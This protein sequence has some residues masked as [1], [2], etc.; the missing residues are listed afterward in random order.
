MKRIL[1]LLLCSIGVLH[2]YAAT[3]YVTQTNYPAGAL[4]KPQNGNVRFIAGET[5]QICTSLS[6]AVEAAKQTNEASTIYV[7]GGT[8]DE[9]LTIDVPNLTLL[10][11]NAFCDVRS[12]DKANNVTNDCVKK[13]GTRENAE[14]IITNK[15]TIIANNVTVNGFQFMGNGCV[16]NLTAT[17]VAPLLGFT[18]LYNVVKNSTVSHDATHA[19][20][21]FGHA[22]AGTEGAPAANCRYGDF[23]IQ[24]NSFTGDADHLSHFIILSGSFGSTYINDNTFYDGGC[25]ITLNNAQGMIDVKH[26]NFTNVGDPARSCISGKM[27]EFCIYLYYIAYSNTTT[28]NIQ[29]NTFNNCQG[30][31]DLFSLIRFFAGDTAAPQMTPTNCRINLNHNVFNNKTSFTTSGHNFVFYTNYTEAADIDTRFNQFS[32]SSQQLAQVRQPWEKKAQR[33]YA[34]SYF[35]IEFASSANTTLGYWK[36]E[37][38]GEIK[39]MNLDKSQRVM[40]SFDIDEETGDIYFVQIYNERET[41]KPEITWTESNGTKHTFTALR[42]LVLSRYYWDASESTM[43]LTHSYLDHAGHGQNMAA[44]RYNGTLYLTTGGAGQDKTNNPNWAETKTEADCHSIFPWRGGCYID[45]QESSTSF[46]KVNPSE[47]YPIKQFVSSLGRGNPYPAVDNTSRLFCERNVSG[48]D[49]KFGIYHLDDVMSQAQPQPIKTI[50]IKKYY[51]SV[52]GDGTN[53]GNIGSEDHGFQT[54]DPQGFTISGDYIYH[55]EGV[56]E[57]NADAID[58]KPTCIIHVHN[59]RTDKLVYRKKIGAKAILSLVHGEPE[60]LK[61]HRDADG[62]PCLL[63]GIA[64]GESGARRANIFKYTPAISSD[65]HRSKSIPTGVSTAS[66]LLDEFN[67]MIFTVNNTESAQTQTFTIQNASEGGG[68]GSTLNGDIHLTVTGKD[69]DNFTVKGSNIG[70]FDKTSMVSVTFM[71]DPTKVFYEANLRISS[72]N[73]ADINI[74]MAASN[75]TL[76]VAPVITVDPQTPIQGKGTETEPF[77]VYAGRAFAYTAHATN[78]GQYKVYDEYIHMD[79]NE[80]EV[81]TTNHTYT[82]TVPAGTVVGT[83]GS[84]PVTARTKVVDATP[85]VSTTAQVYYEVIA[86]PMMKLIAPEVAEWGSTM[87]LGIE[88]DATVAD[89]DVVFTYYTQ[90]PSE[91]ASNTW[92]TTQGTRYCFRNDFGLQEE[93]TYSAYVTMNYQGYTFTSETITFESKKTLQDTYLAEQNYPLTL[94]AL[95]PNDAAEVIYQWTDEN[96]QAISNITNL[97]TTA[98]NVRALVV[99]P[100]ASNFTHKLKLTATATGHKDDANAQKTIFERTVTITDQSILVRVNTSNVPHWNTGWMRLHYWHTNQS[101]TDIPLVNEGDNWYSAFLPLGT[102]GKVHFL[103]HQN[104]SWNN[105]YTSLNIEDISESSCWQIETSVADEGDGERHK[106]SK[107]DNCPSTPEQPYRIV[108]LVGD[109]EYYSNAVQKVGETVSYYATAGGTLELEQW[110]D[111]A[112][113]LLTSFSSLATETGVQVAIFTGN[114]VKDSKLYTGNYYIHTDKALNGWKSYANMQDNEEHKKDAQ[115]LYFS[116]IEGIIDDYNYYWVRYYDFNDE[117]R[118]VKACVG[119]IYNDDLTNTLDGDNLTEWGGIIPTSASVRFGYNATTNTLSRAIVTYQDMSMHAPETGMLYSYQTEG[120]AVD[121]GGNEPRYNFVDA[122]EFCYKMDVWA[123]AGAQCKINAT[124]RNNEQWLF[125]ADKARTVLNGTAGNQLHRIR[126]LYDL[127]TNRITTTYVVDD[128]DGTSE[129]TP[130][131]LLMRRENEDAQQVVLSTTNQHSDMKKL[132]TVLEVTQ[133]NLAATGGFFW[134]SL[135]YACNISDIQGLSTTLVPN[136]PYGPTTDK[137]SKWCIQRY[138]GDKRA[139]LGLFLETPTFWY[140]MRPTATLEANR[141][142]VVYLNLQEGDFEDL[143]KVDEAGQL[144][145]EKGIRLVFPST[146]AISMTHLLETVIPEHT[147]TIPRRKD[148]DSNWNVIGVPGYRNLQ[149]TTWGDQSGEAFYYRWEWKDNKGTY[150]ADVA[151]DEPFK[152]TFAYMVQFA[153]TITWEEPQLKNIVRKEL[154]ASN[155]NETV[156]YLLRLQLSDETLMHTDRTFVQLVASATTDYDLNR[157]LGKIVNEGVLQVYSLSTNAVADDNGGTII[158]QTRYAANNLPIASQYVS[159]GVQVAQ[160]DYYTFSVSDVPT[161]VIPLLYDAETNSTVNLAFDVYTVYLEAGID[162]QRFALRL[163]APDVSTDMSQ[164]TLTYPI[165]QTA[166]GLLI[167]GLTEPTV[168]RIYDTAGRLIFDQTLYNEYI[169]L[170]QTGVY[171]LQIGNR[172]QRILIK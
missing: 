9:V 115:L 25:S 159:L 113:T 73:A 20:I 60:G 21:N 152:A 3:Y 95:L 4:V 91:K 148:Y 103:V 30:R 74:P 32:H 92:G 15:W 141:G 55:F 120:T 67:R 139:E 96:G 111:G 53:T 114:G 128:A 27:G 48:A 10:G 97:R 147:C 98:V 144:T 71:P 140:D 57:G 88:T 86:E 31:G 79:V 38:G 5:I 8:Y 167:T 125:G 101:G 104:D 66:P 156:S 36:H 138:R 80:T 45:L 106:Y 126:I 137:M 61:V 11:N 162:E 46:N 42:P 70:A 41:T 105:D 151:T 93:G 108:S 35:P 65:K 12:N 161:E 110:M 90:S 129:L 63:A 150:T 23:M 123:K 16:E 121:L 112:W 136:G 165:T 130:D 14:S 145:I 6:A 1:L 109:Q 94:D 102:D 26:N 155:L 83:K 133:D 87:S 13:Y 22:V 44:F 169:P 24:H 157:D 56:G 69:K 143:Q 81:S 34:T 100:T 17:N 59:W 47:T 127:K 49:V 28:V 33:N 163:Q 99:T 51:D 124:Y 78:P 149:T 135:P 168:V 50:T 89:D 166:D 116:P 29:N 72:P 119:N 19:V 153:G 171:L 68:S 82:Y 40:Q 39:D 2:T 132:C 164:A 158:E 64:T 84:I 160:A 18:F 77:K 52:D 54:W 62:I 131:V 118:N 117:V 85:T 134:I 75:I 7:D 58:N 76:N 122:G 154:Q 107:I 37:Q 172:T 142:Y 170:M 43:K 146:E